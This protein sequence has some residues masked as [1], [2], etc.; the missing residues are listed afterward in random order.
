MILVLI[1][2]VSLSTQ[3]G[4]ALR[5]QQ[6]YRVVAAD[7][8]ARLR[9][10]YRVG[11]SP[12]EMRLVLYRGKYGE[13]QVC[14]FTFNT[15]QPH[16]QTDGPVQCRGEISPGGVDLTVSGLKG[17]DTDLY[18]CRVEVLYPPPYLRKFGNGTII[19]IPE[20]T[21][22]P[23]TEAQT[24]GEYDSTRFILPIAALASFFL[25][26]I[27]IVISTYKFFI[28]SQRKRMYPH[29]VPVMPKRVD[30]RFG[31]ENFL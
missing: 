27:I 2:L 12:E 14:F 24:Q 26:I 17:E 3:T 20:R 16:I 9:C 31:Y 25:I 18:R 8:E 23:N 30:C 21:D 19:Y 4:K 28:M 6:P 15:S 29:M 13:D 22:C 5:V 10:S 1:T 7:G 11:G